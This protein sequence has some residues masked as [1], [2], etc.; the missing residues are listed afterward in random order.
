MGQFSVSVYINAL[1]QHPELA[2]QLVEYDGFTDI[3]FNPAHSINCQAASAA[4]YVSLQKRNELDATLASAESFLARML[5]ATA[6]T[7]EDK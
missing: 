3:E 5:T 4:L 7:N 2:R 6:T 1:Q